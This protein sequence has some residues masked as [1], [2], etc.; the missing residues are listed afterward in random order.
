MVPSKNL[1]VFRGSLDGE[2]IVPEAEFL[3]LSYPRSPATR[4]GSDGFTGSECSFSTRSQD[5]IVAFLSSA[6]L[7]L[8]GDKVILHLQT[9]QDL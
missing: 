5:L 6:L 2:G 3:V 4:N 7:S 9:W 1:H 8:D